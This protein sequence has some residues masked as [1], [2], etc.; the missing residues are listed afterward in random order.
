VTRV[1]AV[2]ARVLAGEGV[3]LVA[4]EELLSRALE[5]L[6]RVQLAGDAEE[7][8]AALNVFYNLLEREAE[9]ALDA[10][11]L[12]TQLTYKR[13]LAVLADRDERRVLV[14]REGPNWKERNDRAQR[15]LEHAMGERENLG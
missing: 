12:E 14:E 8:A 2:A 5:A 1:Q 7:R 6:E 9:T 4:A 11:R 13:S 15:D 10:I 3:Q